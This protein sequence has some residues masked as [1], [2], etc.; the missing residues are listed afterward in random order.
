MDD[1]APW[2]TEETII[3]FSQLPVLS[4]LSRFGGCY[5]SPYLCELSRFGGCHLSP[6]WW[7]SPFTFAPS[8]FESARTLLQVPGAVPTATVQATPPARSLEPRRSAV[9]ICG[10]ATGPPTG[11]GGGLGPFLAA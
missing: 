1:S 10:L 9:L 4:E 5:I 11:V 2:K 8:T 3:V 6:S 7:L